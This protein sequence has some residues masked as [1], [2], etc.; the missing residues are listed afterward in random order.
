MKGAGKWAVNI[1]L[2]VVLRFVL[3]AALVPSVFSES[4]AIVRSSSS[5]EP[6]MRA[7]ALQAG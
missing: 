2:G 3:F 1:V 5:M 4:L 6:A 7:G